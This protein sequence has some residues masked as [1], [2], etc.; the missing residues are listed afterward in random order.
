MSHLRF[1]RARKRATKLREKIAGVTSVLK[2]FDTLRASV[3]SWFWSCYDVE[4]VS[5]ACNEMIITLTMTFMT[6]PVTVGYRQPRGTIAYRSTNT[7]TKMTALL[8]I[9]SYR[10]EST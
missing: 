3:V 9:A 4:N 8:Y 7:T 6:M 5:S 1:C 2:L 10:K